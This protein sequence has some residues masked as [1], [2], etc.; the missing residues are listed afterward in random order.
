MATF[1]EIV[2]KGN[3]RDLVPYLSGFAAAARA[4]GVYFAEEAGLHLKPLRERIHHHGEVHHV[5]CTEALRG[6]LHDALAKAAPRYRFEIKDE[7]KVERATFSFKVE[8]PSREVAKAVKDAVAKPPRG[9]AVT[10]FVPREVLQPSAKGAEVYS[11]VHDY[12]FNAEGTVDGDIG[13]IEM[14]LKLAAIDFVHCDEIELHE[15]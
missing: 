2:I 9:V 11:P 8:T 13:V 10:G 5:I 15:K 4:R 6:V 7:R 3:D 14:R 12:M 1:C